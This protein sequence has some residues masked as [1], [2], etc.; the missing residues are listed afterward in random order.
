M[1]LPA[2]AERTASH[3]L[4]TPLYPVNRP[5][6]QR[7]TV[8]RQIG[9]WLTG[10]LLAVTFTAPMATAEP[11]TRSLSRAALADKIKGGWAGQMIGVAFGAANGS[12]SDGRND[13]AALTWTPD[14]VVNALDQ[15]DLYVEMTFAKVM[16]EVGLEAVTE[17]YGHALKSSQYHLWH[18]NAAAR[19]ALDQGLPASRSGHPDFNFHANDADFQHEAD[20]IGM[21]C[22]GLPREA[23]RYCERVGRLIGSGD[24]LYGGMF[25]GGMYAAA[26]LQSEPRKV[27]AAGLASVPPGSEYARTIGDVLRWHA[28]HPREWRPVW[29]LVED[30]WARNHG[31]G[32]DALMRCAD[33][34]L[35]GAGVALGLLFGGGD[36]ARTLEISAACGQDSAGT[37]STAAGVLGVM[38]GYETIPAK[39]RAG[40]P[41]IADKEFSFTDYSFNTILRSTTLRALKVVQMA[42][43][44]VTDTEIQIPRQA[45][46][47]PPLEQWRPGTPDQPLAVD[48]AAWTWAGRWQTEAGAKSSLSGGNEVTLRFRGRSVAITGVPGPDGGRADIYLDGTKVGVADGYVAE[49]TH[50][51]VFWHAH[52]LSAGHHTLRMVTTD[53][54]DPRS[55]GTRV[56]INGAVTYR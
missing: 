51:N 52:R 40:L 53:V 21:M 56:T 43:G 45:P 39:F 34:R 48:N 32:E 28:A 31:N 11:A 44:Q 3:P 27:V 47:P 9:Q 23:N 38:L 30:K 22:P 2:A 4:S 49:R 19:R 12:K 6:L 36:F 26:F 54:A 33:A 41:G 18:A 7:T 14:M 8:A 5:T 46:K 35:S 15:D 13:D 29:R 42:G 16:D 24:G 10:G 55:T 1:N 20:F 17:D 37:S 50:E 25:V